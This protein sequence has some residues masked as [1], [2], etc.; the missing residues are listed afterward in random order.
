MTLALF[1]ASRTAVYTISKELFGLFELN[2][3]G[4]SSSLID[5]SKFSVVRAV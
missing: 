4:T 3:W 5:K 1:C 2:L